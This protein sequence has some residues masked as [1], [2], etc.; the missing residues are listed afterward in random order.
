MG[1]FYDCL[2]VNQ[3]A[4][5]DE[6]KKAYKKL[7][8]QLHP[9][10]GGDPE[11]FKEL[12]AAYQ[13]L[14]DDEQ[15]ARYDAVGDQGW[16]QGAGNQGGGG[17]GDFMN[18]NNI[19]EQFFGGG[20]MHGHHPFGGGGG[21]RHHNAPRRCAD[22]RHAMHITL[23]DAF[24]GV[25]K[26]LKAAVKSTCSKCRKTCYACQGVGNVTHVQR[27][28]LFTQMMK[29]QCETCNGSGVQCTGCSEC[30]GRGTW[31]KMH[32]LDLELPPGVST[33][34][35][36]K[37]TGL[38]EQAT[39]QDETPGDLIIE[40]LVQPDRM[41]ERNG[42]DLI[43][44]AMI[45]FAESVLGK[46]LQIPTLDES[47]FTFHSSEWGVIKQGETYRITG[48]GMPKGVGNARG[49]LLLKFKINYPSGKITEEQRTGLIQAFEKCGWT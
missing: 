37:F 32:V 24:R 14:G 46:E 30:D 33:G 31:N 27:M 38:G 26:T 43:M 42:A 28:G 11:K 16:E 2:G 49:D 21:G 5:K 48:R 19:F 3:T 15:R 25:K 8:V 13:V 41:F 1:K 4:S 47:S 36:K 23:S 7:A 40:V 6:I 17:P 9:D 39:R 44:T 35:A 18:A 20:G 22:H 45:S 34:W 10:K 29:R 12:S